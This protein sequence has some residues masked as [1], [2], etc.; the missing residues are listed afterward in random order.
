MKRSAAASLVLLLAAGL[1]SAQS[2]PELF[3]KLKEQV[4]AESWKDA[5]STA[6]ALEAQ[7]GKP[8]NEA[9]RDQLAGP[10][11]FYRGVCEANTGQT[12]KAVADFGTFL[13]VQ[14]NAEINP[15][16]YSKKAV[17]AFDSARKEAAGR[18][19]SLAEAYKEFQAPTDAADRD[20][21]DAY[22]ADGPTR[23]IL[24]PAEKKSW[25]ALTDPNARVAFVEQFWSA[26]AGLPGADG[27]T[28]QQ[29][30]EK[31]VAF[32]DAYL[33]EEEEQRGSMTD[34]GMVFV[35]MGPPT[36]AGRKP[37]RTGDDKSDDAG[38]ST[39]GSHD[40]MGAEVEAKDR[41]YSRTGKS[42]SGGKISQVNAGFGG[43]GTKGL[44]ASQNTEEIWHYRRELLP[45]GAPYQ[46][47]D[48]E[49]VTKKG[50]GANVLQRTSE[51]TNTLDAAKATTR[52]P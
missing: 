40:A 49:F 34:R 29:E 35:L 32:A 11:A 10:L 27:R 3:A 37:L 4:K 9:V 15:K 43:P 8:G 41:T 14:P 17:E 46:Q 12:D 30:F 28:Y 50:Y 20:R 45:K 19:P 1:S 25:S 24:T 31:R 6:S 2:M 21:A 44:E 36:Y 23:W 16:V 52:N 39:E 33:A 7:A 38:L 48:F 42:A 5:L 22:W 13:K 47:V 26:R 51:T 18:A